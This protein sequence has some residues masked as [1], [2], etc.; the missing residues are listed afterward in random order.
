MTAKKHTARRLGLGFYE[1]R[2]HYILRFRTRQF[3]RN[4][5]SAPK[6]A[7]IGG[8]PSW[9]VYSLYCPE[10]DEGVNLDHRNVTV[11]PVGCIA[12]RGYSV[13]GLLHEEGSDT[14]QAAKEWVDDLLHE[15]SLREKAER[16]QRT[17]I[18]GGSPVGG[19]A[20]G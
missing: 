3:S 9:H 8:P 12:D 15:R 4:Y 7:L 17:I 19:N 5:R 11:P 13:F 16:D 18:C 14:L 1:Y 20:R 6:N 2:G 10:M